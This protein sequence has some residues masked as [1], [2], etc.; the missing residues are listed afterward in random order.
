MQPKT[1]LQNCLANIA[2]DPD[3]VAGVSA[4]T[5]E[6]YYLQEIAKNSP[7]VATFSHDSTA[8][9][10]VCDLTWAAIKAA[11]EAGKTVVAK[12]STGTKAFVYLYLAKS[13]VG[14]TGSVVFQGDVWATASWSSSTGPS[15]HTYYRATL[16]YQ[17]AAT[18]ESNAA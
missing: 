5:P 9:K 3:A 12:I 2:G 14:S 16:T 4:K 11:V 8:N 7:L 18:I 13:D 15:A 17:D 1:A 10:D 6:Q